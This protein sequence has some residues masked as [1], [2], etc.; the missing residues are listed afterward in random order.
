MPYSVKRCNWL[1]LLGVSSTKFDK[2]RYDIKE[3]DFSRGSHLIKVTGS[4][5]FAL[6]GPSNIGRYNGISQ[7]VVFKCCLN[8]QNAWMESVFFNR[9]TFTDCVLEIQ[10][11]VTS[12]SSYNIINYVFYK[13][14]YF[15]ESSMCS[16]TCFWQVTGHFWLSN[17]K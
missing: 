3:I 14:I 7:S 16:V 17:F 15:Y 4:S 9:N 1:M 6:T 13:H 11:N 12:F 2:D 8:V 5:W 10:I